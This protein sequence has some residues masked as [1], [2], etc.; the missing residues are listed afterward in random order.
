MPRE[1]IEHGGI[2][3]SSS[4]VGKGRKIIEKYWLVSEEGKAREILNFNFQVFWKI[5]RAIP[6]LPKA[7]R[8]NSQTFPMFFP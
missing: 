2:F 7:K 3:F 6:H 4:L 1:P 8:K 5:F